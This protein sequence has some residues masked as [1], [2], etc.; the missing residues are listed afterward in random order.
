MTPD[1][2]ITFV[3]GGARSGKS[4]FALSRASAI[5]GRKAYIATAQ[6]FDDEMKA[7]IMAHKLDREEGW[8]TFEEPLQ[9]A[10]TVREALERYEVIV[11]D[12]MTLWLSNLLLQDKEIEKETRAFHSSL[13][14]PHSSRFFLVSNEVG[15]GIVPVN[16]LARRFRDL[17]GTLNQM[18]AGIADE[19]YLVTAGIP[20]RIK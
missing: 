17:A 7:R 9:L 10:K 20:L 8:D 2:G 5:P 6:A 14:S 12:C 18:I 1:Q 3:L 16:D 13:L 15:M 11:I 19:V 4:S